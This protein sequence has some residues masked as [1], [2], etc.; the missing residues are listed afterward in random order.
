MRCRMGSLRGGG[1]EE[2]RGGEGGD[3]GGGGFLERKFWRISLHSSS[4]EVSLQIGTRK[5]EKD[6]ESI[7]TREDEKEEA[8]EEE[9]EER[10]S[11]KS[12][13]R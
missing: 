4:V 13:V 6:E 8:D 5:V 12:S 11:G 2:G 7:S 1:G 3:E 9:E 10:A